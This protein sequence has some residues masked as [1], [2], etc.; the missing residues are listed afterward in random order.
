[1]PTKA[2]TTW[3][4]I[5]IWCDDARFFGILGINCFATRAKEHNREPLFKNNTGSKKSIFVLPAD[6][7]K[8]KMGQEKK[9]KWQNTLIIYP[10]RKNSE[11]RHK[12]ED[13]TTS[14]SNRENL[15]GTSA[16]VRAWQSGQTFHGTLGTFSSLKTLAT[17]QT[18]QTFLT[19][20][21]YLYIVFSKINS[22]SL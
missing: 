18:C 16:K 12:G 21:S 19:F 2:N 3:T 22:F 1:M 14:V 6:H 10:A 15:P 13:V 5:I 20:T 11:K 8:R 4:N 9:K 17:F 7:G